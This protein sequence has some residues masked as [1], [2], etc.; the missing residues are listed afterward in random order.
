M[1]HRITIQYADTVHRITIRHTDQ[2][3]DTQ[4]SYQIQGLTLRHRLTRQKN[5]QT[6]FNY[7]W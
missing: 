7:G 1:E 2:I 3:S 4:T 6:K 5:Q